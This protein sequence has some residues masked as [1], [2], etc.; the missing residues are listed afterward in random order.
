MQ[1]GPE[2]HSRAVSCMRLLCRFWPGEREPQPRKKLPIPLSRDWAL[3]AFRKFVD[4]RGLGLVLMRVGG[5]IREVVSASVDVI[6][7]IQV[8]YTAR[9][10]LGG[11]G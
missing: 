2:R 8:T 6:I 3:V 11:S 5:F 1:P 4:R 10:H 7:A 9:R